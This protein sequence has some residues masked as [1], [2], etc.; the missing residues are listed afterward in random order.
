MACGPADTTPTQ[1]A[2]VPPTVPGETPREDAPETPE[3]PELPVEEGVRFAEHIDVIVDNTFLTIINPFLPAGNTTSSQWAYTLIYD[4]LI[5]DLGG[6][7]YGPMLA[8]DWYS[9]D[10]TLWRFY[11]RDDVYFHNG[12]HFTAND[13][14]GTIRVAQAH[15]GTLAFDRWRTVEGYNIIDDYTIEILLEDMHVDF[16]FDISSPPGG[17][18]NETAFWADADEGVWIGTGPFYVTEFS[19]NDFVTVNRN[20]AFWGEMTPTQSV[21]LRFVPEPAARLVMMQNH[22]SDVS[23]G[24][25]PEDLELLAADPGFVLFPVTFNSPNTLVFNMSDPLMADSNFRRAVFHALNLEE[26]A[27]A[28]AGQWTVAPQDGNVWG[29]ATEFRHQGIPRWEF[30][31][32]LA[33]EYLAASPYNGE[34][35]ELSVAIATNIRAIEIV[36]IHL[37]QIGINTS[38]N[39]MDTAGLLSHVQFGNN[40]SQ[41]HLFGASFTLSALGSVWNVYYP[42]TGNNRSSFNNPYISELII[43]ARGT[44]DRAEREAIIMHIQEYIAQDPPMINL[45]WRLN[46]VSAIYGVGGINLGYDTLRYDLRGVFRVLHD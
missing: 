21:T 5:Q 15:P 31:Q 2:I 26:I 34:V 28:A 38:I 1:S 39:S 6:G 41:I 3:M 25:T 9:S 22:E 16:L 44:A 32:D 37:E 23:F 18:I 46:A 20:D 11:L 19:T 14:A 43:R 27:M 35:I 13:V 17:I 45:F 29:P 40:Q 8:N 36:Q 33:R 4:R 42:G 10:A 12:D 30:N 7:N 24:T